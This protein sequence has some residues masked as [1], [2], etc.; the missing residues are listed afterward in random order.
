MRYVSH[1]YDIC[2]RRLLSWP[3]QSG[4]TDIT[5]TATNWVFATPDENDWWSGLW[6]ERTTA[7]GYAKLAVD[8]GH[9]TP[10]QQALSGRRERQT[11]RRLS[12]LRILISWAADAN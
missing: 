6:A 2:H 3:R 4:L 10:E 11:G 9:A 1:Q 12:G 8:G 7:S 5:P